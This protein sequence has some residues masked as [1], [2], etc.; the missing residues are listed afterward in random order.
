MAR[1]VQASLEELRR[2]PVRNEIIDRKAVI[3]GLCV[4]ALL[5]GGGVVYKFSSPG[6]PVPSQREFEFAVEEPIVEKFEMTEPQRDIVTEKPEDMKDDVKEERPDV[7]MTVKPTDIKPTEEVISTSQVQIDTPD[8]KV[9]ATEVDVDAPVEISEKSTDVQYQMSII[10]AK[11]SEP[12]DIFLYKDP[13]PRDKPAMYLINRAPRA[14]RSLSVLPKAFGDKDAPSYGEIGPYNINLSGTGDFFR[15]MTKWGGVQARSAVDSALRWLA[16]HQE[17][18]GM[19]DC[20]RWGGEAKGDTG[21]TGLA[22]LAFLG[23]GNTTRKGEYRRNVLRGL[24]ALMKLQDKNGAVDK[25]IYCHSMAT[26]ALC[27]AYGRARDE[28]V[29]QAARK[30]VDYLIKGV[31]PDGGW[32]YTANCG[33]SDLSVTAWAVQA[34]KA[35][36]LA[37]ISF[38]STIYS[39]ALT[40]TDSV[41]DKGGTQASSGEVGYT[42][43]ET[44]TYS[45]HTALTAAGMVVRQFSNVGIKNHLLVKAAE[46]MRKHEPKWGNG[47]DIY[48]WYYA[49]Y[50]MHNMGGEHRVWWNRRI[51]DVLIENQL[52]TGEHAGSWEYQGDRWGP[53]G[54]RVYMT[55]LG[56]LCLEVYYRYGEALNSFGVAPDI[57]DL[58]LQGGQ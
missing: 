53:R 23:S 7:H 52:K 18:G 38:D 39:R 49:T 16:V 19:W 14:G 42:Y 57:D 1:N 21:V 26:I 29:G 5:V 22:L 56:A 10:A 31:N 36:K 55:A 45:G 25:N 20:Q 43:E 8:I 32:R 13:T 28:R 15:T 30:A 27:E 11:V 37:E 9:K 3:Y 33:Q 34:L 24:E 6:T 54:G 35:A 48:M 40:F 46:L 47:R 50:G 12:A 2:H 4:F 44:Q 17:S 41:T 58:F 51:R